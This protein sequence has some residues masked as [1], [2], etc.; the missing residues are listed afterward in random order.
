[1]IVKHEVPIVEIKAHMEELWELSSA[2]VA[3]F[4]YTFFDYQLH[5]GSFIAAVAS[6][7]ACFVS[8]RYILSHVTV[9]GFLEMLQLRILVFIQQVFQSSVP[10]LQI[11]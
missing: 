8:I 5:Y 1:M 9:P 6:G 3:N 2:C 10:D 11:I 4:G 7:D